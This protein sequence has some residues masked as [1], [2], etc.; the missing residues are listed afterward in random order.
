MIKVERTEEP[1]I[2]RN[3]KEEWLN[4]LRCATSKSEKEKIAKKYRH[5]QIK[6]ALIDMLNDKCAYCES[7]IT[8][9]EWGHIE[10]YKPKSVYEE[11]TFEWTNLLLACSICNVNKDKKFPVENDNGPFINPCDDEPNDHFMFDF[12]NEIASVYG[13]TP[14]GKTTEELLDLN[15]HDLRK[16]R[17]E[18][19]KMIACI[20]EFSEQDAAASNIYQ[21]S[22]L[23]SAEYAAFARNL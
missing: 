21:E 13:I 19:I 4:Q 15:R 17:T 16:K 6:Q 2:L 22:L 8:H 18:H 12:S 11:L 3:N 23:S 14:R 5:S 7:K 20:K 9:I 10:H 1:E